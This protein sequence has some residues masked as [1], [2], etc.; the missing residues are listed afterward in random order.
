[1]RLTSNQHGALR[2]THDTPSQGFIT[3]MRVISNQYEDLK[4]T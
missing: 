4:L 1:M 3:G 2:M